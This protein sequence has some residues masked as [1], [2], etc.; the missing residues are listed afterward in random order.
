[1]ENSNYSKNRREQ[2]KKNEFNFKT[3]YDVKCFMK[4]EFYLEYKYPRGIYSRIDEFKVLVGPIFKLIEKELTKLDC[5]VKKISIHD[6]IKHIKKI[7]EGHSKVYV[8][9]YTSFEGSFSKSI[10]EEVEFELYRFM[11]SNIKSARFMDHLKHLTQ[12]NFCQF[13]NFWVKIPATRMS[14]E[15]N[16][17][18][19]NTF[20][21]MILSRFV[22]HKSGEEISCIFEGDDGMIGSVGPLDLTIPAKLGFNLKHE[23][24]NIN[25]AS[26]C[27]M[28]FDFDDCQYITD[29]VKFLLKLGWSKSAYANASENK[30]LSL[31]KAKCQSGLY[32]YRACPVVSKLLKVI[33]RKLDERKIRARF[34]ISTNYE[35]KTYLENMQHF[36]S[37]REEIMGSEPTL[38]TRLL[39]EK[40]F[41][42]DIQMQ[43][44][45]EQ[46]FEAWEPNRPMYLGI[47][48]SVHCYNYH[49]YTLP[50][51]LSCC[52]PKLQKV[53]VYETSIKAKNEEKSKESGSQIIRE[54][55]GSCDTRACPKNL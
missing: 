33:L 18:L 17:S 1:M 31:L 53:D 10:M 39:F 50:A 15:M 55:Y 6:R 3:N 30:L 54:T 46:M 37:N 28:I 9:D 5:F 42:I 14:G 27:G 4:D 22:A 32:L 19:G 23:L 40:L 24:K 41:G 25:E 51:Y 35:K 38:K 21:N 29:P 2:L 44:Y 34:G 13:K 26:F 45:Y 48:T 12:S 11:T 43:A 47:G 52:V 7:F 36:Y 49:N 20:M 16:T 8:T